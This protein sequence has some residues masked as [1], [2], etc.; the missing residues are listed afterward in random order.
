MAGEFP[1]SHGAGPADEDAAGLVFG[2]PAAS[3]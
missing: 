1:K 2:V 3:S